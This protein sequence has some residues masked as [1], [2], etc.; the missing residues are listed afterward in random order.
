MSESSI[1]NIRNGVIASVIAGI[2]LLLIPTVRSYASYALDWIGY[3]LAL[4][5]FGIAFLKIILS[6][7]GFY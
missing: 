6:Q 4:N 3:G 2:I 7:A 5:G 1:K